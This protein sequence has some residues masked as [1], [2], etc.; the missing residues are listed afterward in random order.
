MKTKHHRFL[1]G[2]VALCAG[3]C[4][5]PGNDA[6]AERL[7]MVG[8]SGGINPNCAVGPAGNSYFIEGYGLDRFGNKV[9]EVATMIGSEPAV[10]MCEGNVL[11]LGWSLLPARTHTPRITIR[12]NV[13]GTWQRIQELPTIPASTTSADWTSF[14]TVRHEAPAQNGCPAQTIFALTRGF[15]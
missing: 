11:N 3:L 15:N 2:A 5:L 4:P 6:A 10:G 12:T 9:C 13:S 8:G 7:L 14:A 1:I